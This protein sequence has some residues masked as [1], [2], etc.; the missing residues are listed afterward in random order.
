MSDESARRV[1][2]AIPTAEDEGD[3]IRAMDDSCGFHHPWISPPRGA[4][5]YQHFLERV[6]QNDECAFLLRRNDSNEICGVVA[7]NLIVYQALC[8]AYLSYYVVQ[9]Y[10]QAGLMKEG[11]KLLIEHAF[12]ELDLHRLEANV[13]PGNT[14][15]VALVRSLGFRREGFSPR[16]LKIGGEWRDHERW[17]LLADTDRDEES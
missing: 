14:A 3:F 9:K 8:S 10:S 4:K 12:N 15:S 7:L 2:L 17:A 5:S 1:R 16:Y 11:L 6:S 13:Q